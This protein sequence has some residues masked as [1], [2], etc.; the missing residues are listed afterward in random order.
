MESTRQRL[1]DY[2]SLRRLAT[3]L[4]LSRALHSTPANI[5][6]H[7]SMLLREGIVEIVNP[8][9]VK[10]RGR[11]A[12]LY[13]LARQEGHHNLGTLAH[14]L[15]EEINDNQPLDERRRFLRRLA[16]HLA[17]GEVSPSRIAGVRLLHTIQ[18]LNEMHYGARWEAHSGGPNVIL[19]HCP[20]AS[21]IQNHPELCQMDAYLLEQ[22]SGM[23]ARQV[24]KLAPS[25]LGGVQCVFFLE[26]P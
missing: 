19:T 4:E 6:H 2:L 8:R 14:A 3:S 18:R 22:M 5:R 10:G 9:V 17:S 24:A 1:L 20:Y 7:L 21:I 25:H 12:R 15:L 11:P 16:R 23:P 13:G 26:K